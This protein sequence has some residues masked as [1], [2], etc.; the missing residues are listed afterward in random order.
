MSQIE[1]A[2]TSHD[3]KIQGIVT[4]NNQQ[5]ETEHA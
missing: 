4:R 3:G 5:A 2:D 1:S